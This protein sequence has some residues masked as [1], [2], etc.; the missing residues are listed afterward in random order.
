MKDVS[1]ILYHR[2]VDKKNKFSFFAEK[3]NLKKIDFDKY[4]KSISRAKDIFS[5]ELIIK[6]FKLFESKINSEK[7]IFKW[8]QKN[9][10]GIEK[11]YSFTAYS[12]ID[13]N[14]RSI[15]SLENFD[16]FY[17]DI[18]EQY[19]SQTKSI[20][21]I[22]LTWIKNNSYINQTDCI[23]F[24]CGINERI[25]SE[26][27]HDE[28]YMCKT[29]RNRGAW[30]ELD[31]RDSSTKKNVYTKDNMVLCCYFCNNHK[32]DVVSVKD[33]RY[34]FGE[35]MF[36]FLIDKYESIMKSKQK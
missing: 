31:R 7:E 29:K 17:K 25:L 26:L 34:Y 16:L 20:L 11:K 28:K 6:A 8:N 4:Y 12:K 30:F 27:Y 15:K 13:E 35:K 5:D 14:G 1:E 22:E 19:N 10:K 36:Q 2:L 21:Q 33:M 32:S 9:S 23:C 18:E 3:F 24:Y